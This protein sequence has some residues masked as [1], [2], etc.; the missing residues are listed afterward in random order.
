MQYSK[1]DTWGLVGF[2]KALSEEEITFVKEHIKTLGGK[3]VTW[4]HLD[5]EYLVN[6]DSGAV[7]MPMDPELH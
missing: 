1:G 6:S 4:S 3:E 7:I 5:G 2:D